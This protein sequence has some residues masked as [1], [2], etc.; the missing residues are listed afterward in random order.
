[1]IIK[2]PNV[3]VRDRWWTGHAQQKKNWKRE[4]WMIKN[5]P[6]LPKTWGK[7]KMWVH[8]GMDIRFWVFPFD[9]WIKVKHSPSLFLRKSCRHLIIFCIDIDGSGFL[10]KLHI[11]MMS[12][13]IIYCAWLSTINHRHQ[14]WSPIHKTSI[15]GR[16]LALS[17]L[18]WFH[19]IFSSYIFNAKWGQNRSVT[20]VVWCF[21][22]YH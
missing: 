22:P 11:Y 18:P 17:S 13:K 12:A 1:M 10:I 7:I 8:E 4:G 20:S 5:I 16:A 2:D 14:P 6:S 15:N 3:S 21:Q 19:T 9:T